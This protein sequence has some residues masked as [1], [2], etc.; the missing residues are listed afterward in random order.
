MT[1]LWPHQVRICQAIN[2][3]VEWNGHRLLIA[4]PTGAGKSRCMF[5]TCE[6]HCHLPIV[7]YTHRRMLLDQ[8]GRNLTD[9]GFEFGVRASGHDTDLERPLQL[10]MIQTEQSR[11]KVRG[12]HE[13]KLVIID[14]AHTMKAEVA[15]QIVKEH[16]EQ[17]ATIV[18]FTA[19]PV[20]LGHMYDE[21]I[22]GAYNSELRQCGAHLP[23]YH[24]APDSIDTSQM[25]RAKTGEYLEGD[26]IKAI[27]TPTIFGRVFEHWQMLNPQALPTILFAPGV[28]HSL[29]FAQQFYEAGVNAAH[30]DAT[31]IWVDG[32]TKNNTDK[33]RENL[34][35]DISSNKIK[36]ICNRFVMRE[37]VD[38]CELY[39]A[40][41]ATAF[42][43]I[44]SYLQAGG[45]IL[46]NHPSL[47]HVIV[48]DH[49]NNVI[50]HGSLNA[51]R[52]WQLGDTAEKLFAL[53]AERLREQREEEPIICTQCFGIRASGP[54][55]PICGHVENRRI[56]RVIQTDGSLKL[57]E[58][59][60]YKPFRIDHKKNAAERWRDM[61]YRGLNSNMT[62]RQC[63]GLYAKESGDY[64]YPS[65]MLPL[66]PINPDDMVK[67]VRD[68][69][70][71]DLR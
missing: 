3:R 32:K 14:E 38:I 17:G 29:W 6:T 16:K 37:G 35:N 58:G 48:Q 44:Q 55:C 4:A 68:V 25:R 41:F 54:R 7:I 5:E 52:Q 2:D 21:L 61:Y 12:L 45:R 49:G 71:G 46:R 67:R 53:R 57:V 69:A 42:G 47:S 56:R 27:M 31:S 23:C 65:L 59:N 24:Y 40:I 63:R 9:A 64:T 28:P 33:N 66:M 60:Y 50:H 43:S 39:H 1:Q 8:L 26:V 15:S 51:D 13:S 30:I 11:K 19:T 34:L 70:K 18:G 10:A 20:D 36:I 62:F 22:T